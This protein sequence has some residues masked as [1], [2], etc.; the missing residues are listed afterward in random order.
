MRRLSALHVLN[1]VDFDDIRV[2]KPCSA[3]WN[4]MA[5]DDRVRHCGACR[6]NVYNVAGLTKGEV[7]ALLAEREKGRVCLRLSRRADGTLITADCWERLREARRR[8][9][10]AFAVALVLV[11]L[12]QLGLRIAMVRTAWKHLG[13]PPI[14]T[15]G[16]PRPVIQTPG[17]APVGP[18]P[19]QTI[20][21]DGMMVQPVDEQPTPPKRRAIPERKRPAKPKQVVEIDGLM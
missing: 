2:A 12:T 15:P 18:P 11:A 8:G 14:T 20:D 13:K 6:L 7:A 3:D 16:E 9:W 10:Y 19:P 17:L 1:A 4:D 5:G 21:V